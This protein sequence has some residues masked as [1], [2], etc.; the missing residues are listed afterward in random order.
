MVKTLGVIFLGII[1]SLPA[2]ALSLSLNNN[3]LFLYSQNQS[4][5][6]LATILALN[7]A[8]VTFMIGTLFSV[9][10]K[11]GKVLFD[12]TRKEL[13]D[14]VV[15]MI[16]LFI[17]NFTIVAANKQPLVLSFN[18]MNLNIES[19]LSSLTVL[20]TVLTVLAMYEIVQACFLVKDFFDKPSSKK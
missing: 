4:I 12:S 1:I 7:V 11:A 15:F 8:V 18:G 10:A 17:L 13:Q 2:I 14:N 6:V 19:L 20:L 9:E 5:S 16:F 3:F